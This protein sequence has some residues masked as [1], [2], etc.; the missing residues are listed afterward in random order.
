MHY[1]RLG[2]T[3]LRLS[4]IAFGCWATLGEG[5]DI[6][7][8]RQ[9]M[10]TAYDHGINFFDGAETYADGRSEEA[11]GQ[12]LRRASWPRETYVLSSKVFWGVHQKRPNTWGLSRKHVVEG[13][14][15]AMRRLNT[16]YLDLYLCHRYDE[17]APLEETVTAM[18]DLVR[19]GHVL[20]WGTSQWSPEQVRAARDLARANGL[21][22]PVVEQLRYNALARDDVERVFAPVADDLG[23]GLTTW[24]PLAY[25]LLAGRYDHGVRTGSRLAESRYGWLRRDALGADENVVLGRARRFS[26]LAVDLGT[27]PGR[28]A[29]A[30]VLRN[31]TVA[32]AICGAS[33]VAQLED[34]LGA[35]DLI[36]LFDDGPELDRRIDEVCGVDPS[37]G[38][39]TARV[40]DATT[41]LTKKG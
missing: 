30:W 21:V 16:D 33:T 8:G 4:A 24:S 15:A 2:S 6:E 28:L 19:Q 31:R 3:G 17:T 41:T 26:A 27:S 13:C 7:E 9:L 20:Y 18:S 32:S 25:G 40:T 29:L 34:T 1:R 11:V 36:E 12:I 37:G 35:V 5:V 10:A 14:H 22:P 38:A 23:I 39:T